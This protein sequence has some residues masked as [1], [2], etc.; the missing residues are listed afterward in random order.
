MA[1]PTPTV[2]ELAAR[3]FAARDCAHRA[4]WLTVSYAA[5]NALGAFYAALPEAIDDIVEVHQG[6]VGRI[7]PFTVTAEPVAD[8]KAYLTDEADWIAANRDALAQGSNA[9]ANLIDGLVAH[10]RRAVYMLTLI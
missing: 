3:V 1:E 8:I 4:H 9:V 6:E 5:H 7:E 10:Y 2:S